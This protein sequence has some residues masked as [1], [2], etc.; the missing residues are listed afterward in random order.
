MHSASISSEL[1]GVCT[2]KIFERCTHRKSKAHMAFGAA[3]QTRAFVLNKNTRTALN[4]LKLYISCWE[5]FNIKPLSKYHQV[6]RV[7]FSAFFLR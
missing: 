5:L 3:A 1:E 2:L 7:S 6:S 4:T